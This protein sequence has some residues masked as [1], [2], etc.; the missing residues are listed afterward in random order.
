MLDVNDRISIP[1]RE[2]EFEFSRSG[3]PGGQNVNKVATAVHLI[4][5]PSGIEVR[6]QDTKSQAQ[7]REKAWKLLRA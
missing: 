3:G 5:E 4:H 2:L 1:L 6:M 7:N